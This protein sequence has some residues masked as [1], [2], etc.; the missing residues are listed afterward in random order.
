MPTLPA[1]W[2]RMFRGWLR[3]SGSHQRRGWRPA[4]T[5]LE[6]RTLP[7][8]FGALVAAGDLDADGHLDVIA[9]AGPNGAPRVRAFSGRDGST[10]RD[11]FAYDSSAR[12]G[13]SVAAGD[14]DGDGYADL[15]TG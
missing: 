1:I 4:L 14:L 6:D 7:T 8:A 10:L 11:F 15:V 13:V 3:R 2:R 12:G 5:P 9:G